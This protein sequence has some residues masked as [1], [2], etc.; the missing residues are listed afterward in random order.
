MNYRFY[1]NAVLAYWRSEWTDI[2]DNDKEFAIIL[3]SKLNNI[4][5]K[6]YKSNMSVPNAA[7]EI[8][9]FFKSKTY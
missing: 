6:C 3:T 9:V 1:C 4:I 7:K 8:S 5:K 2:K